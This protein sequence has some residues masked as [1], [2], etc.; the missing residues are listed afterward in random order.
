L[1]CSTPLLAIAED[2]AHLRGTQSRPAPNHSSPSARTHPAARTPM[3]RSRSFEKAPDA[4]LLSTAGRR[5]KLSPCGV[6]EVSSLLRAPRAQFLSD[7]VY[8]LPNP[9]A[10][11]PF[12]VPK[13]GTL[14]ASP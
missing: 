4:A 1:Y 10:R 8:G 5:R 13:K 12:P 3:P 9:A 11:A 2:T 14:L 7:A 6:S